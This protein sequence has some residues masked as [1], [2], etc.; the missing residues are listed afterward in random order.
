MVLDI[1]LLLLIV[2]IVAFSAAEGLARSALMVVGFYILCILLGMVLVA[3][4]VAEALVGTVT[5]S[6]TG[7]PTAPSFYQ[8]LVFIGLLIPSFIILVI[9][10]HIAFRETGIAALGWLDS[11]LATLLG[12]LLGL[13]A[14]A[15]I[16]NTWGVVVSTRWQPDRTWVALRLVWETSVLRPFMMDVLR[17]YRGLLFPFAM[18]GY[19]IFFIPQA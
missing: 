11:A 17:T 12:A 9:L 10:S 19:P 18:S 1:L 16:C 6:I 2:G 5:N 15:V 13:A 8:G 7:G 4:D 14:A 3:F